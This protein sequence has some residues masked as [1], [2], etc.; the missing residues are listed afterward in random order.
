MNQTMTRRFAQFILMSDY[1]ERYEAATEDHRQIIPNEAKVLS[2][3]LKGYFTSL[4]DQM[5]WID[6]HKLGVDLFEDL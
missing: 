3:G 6:V 2:L 4:A 1:I 5:N